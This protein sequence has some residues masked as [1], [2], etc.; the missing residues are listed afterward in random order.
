MRDYFTTTLTN[1]DASGMWNMTQAATTTV[2]IV[3]FCWK[4]VYFQKI[5]S[6]K[7]QQECF[8]FQNGSQKFESRQFSLPRHLF[9]TALW[10]SNMGSSQFW[11]TSTAPA[12]HVKVSKKIN[13]IKFIFTWSNSKSQLITQ[14]KYLRLEIWPNL[15]KQGSINWGGRGPPK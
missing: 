3:N 7:K 1:F 15:T 12:W 6:E 9:K 8:L 5:V 13:F 10:P 4:I 14:P 11:P 2:R